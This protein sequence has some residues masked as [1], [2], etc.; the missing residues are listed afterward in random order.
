MEITL[1]E[2]NKPT[3]G[4]GD[5]AKCN[6]RASSMA[7]IIGAN[8]GTF[9]DISF[10][11][12]I[13]V[14]RVFGCEDH[15]T[16]IV[17]DAPRKAISRKMQISILPEI[18][19]VDNKKVRLE[20]TIKLAADAS[21]ILITV[22]GQG[23]TPNEGHFQYNC[24]QVITVGGGAIMLYHAAHWF[25]EKSGREIEARINRDSVSYILVVFK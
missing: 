12:N 14:F 5:S 19:C 2:Q 1:L 20:A 16:T 21:I 9:S 4:K 15:T 8:S 23:N 17:L 7:G 18:K 22:A 10:N 6:R 3:L 24:D 11:A 13:S 25:E